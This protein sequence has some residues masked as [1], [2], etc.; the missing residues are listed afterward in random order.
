MSDLGI[1]D[2]L[3]TTFG[4]YIDSGFGLLSGDVAFLSRTLI[5]IDVT[6]AG[7]FW[8]FDGENV[9]FPRLIRK[10]LY[11]GAFA[12]ILN[13]F[14]SLADIV[15][16]SFSNLGIKATGTGLSP[17]DLLRPGE[18]AATGYQAAHPLLDQPRQS[19]P[20]TEE[21]N[22]IKQYSANIANEGGISHAHR[23]SYAIK[24]RRMDRL[25]SYPDHPQHKSPSGA[26]RR[27]HGGQRS[28]LPCSRRELPRWLRMGR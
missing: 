6:L 4:Q 28:G 16:Q 17:A 19:V 18:I 5:G 7:L 3:M 10:V 26:K 12:F 24:R 20:N 14:K 13:N 8:A 25:H 9:I 1:I 15:F 2:N 22:P 23:E 11:V 21:R 27:P